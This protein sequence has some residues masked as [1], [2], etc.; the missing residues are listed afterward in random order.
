MATFILVAGIFNATLFAR[1]LYEFVIR[2]HPLRRIG[3]F[4]F[5]LVFLNMTAIW[6]S[7]FTLPDYDPHLF[8]LPAFIH[9]LGLAL[10][11]LGVLLFVGTTIQLR[12]MEKTDALIERGL[13]RLFRHPM[14]VGFILW[15][16]GFPLYRG[17]F[18][19]LALGLFGIVHVFYWQ[20][21][22]EKKLVDHYGEQYL[23]YRKRVR[24]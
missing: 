7:W 21:M 24:F 14:Y 3:W 22:E 8:E 18:A 19:S 13:F 5:S 15:L 12:G 2:H 16:V 23:A 9:I 4:V 20:V 6:M 1:S 10:S 17:S 11:L